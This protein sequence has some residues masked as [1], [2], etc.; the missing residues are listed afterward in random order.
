MHLQFLQGIIGFDDDEEEEEELGED[1]EEEGEEEEE[2]E[3]SPRPP[4]P[5]PPSRMQST[6]ARSRT[7]PPPPHSPFREPLWNPAPTLRTFY[8]GGRRGGLVVGPR[9]GLACATTPGG[10]EAC[11]AWRRAWRGQVGVLGARVK[12]PV[13]LLSD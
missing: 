6:H 10:V 1:E 3:V 11:L 13:G 7:A 5:L 4:M 2:E 9:A 8:L 12:S